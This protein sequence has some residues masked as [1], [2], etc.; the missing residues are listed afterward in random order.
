MSGHSILYLGHGEFAPEYLGE[1]ET[2]P[3]C[4]YL[5]RSAVLELP[6][7]ASYIV[8][9]VLLEAGPMI[10]QSGQSLSELIT[11][12]APYPVIALTQKEHEHRGIAAVRAGAQGYICVDDITVEVQESTFDHAVKRGQMQSRLSGSDVS[13]LSVL[14]NINDGAIVVDNSGHVLD[15]NQRRVRFWAS[16]L[17]CC[18]IRPGNRRFA[19]LMETGTATGTP[20]TC[21]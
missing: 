1:L 6:E 19:A 12:L 2:L 4:T 18:R 10:A 8:D 5:T 14:N 3:C 13:V 21:H 17:G 11:R 16:A 7:D 9:L 20:R 15:I